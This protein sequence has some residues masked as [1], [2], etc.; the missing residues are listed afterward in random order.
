MNSGLVCV[1]RK[2][3]PGASSV[4]VVSV[5]TK[6]PLAH[7]TAPIITINSTS[8]ASERRGDF[9]ERLDKGG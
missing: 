6:F 3:T 5:G 2:N 8:T 7:V 9:M 1:L 4:T